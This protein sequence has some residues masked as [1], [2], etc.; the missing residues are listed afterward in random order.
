MEDTPIPKLK[1][2][3]PPRRF[4]AR[5]PRKRPND[6]RHRRFVSV[7]KLVLPLIAGTLIMLVAIWP[8]LGSEKSGF[9]IGFANL[10]VG[11]VTSQSLV[12]ARYE[13]TDRNERP[14]TVT[15]EL[16]TQDPGGAK[17]IRLI[18]PK[19]DILLDGGAW[20]VL[21]AESGSFERT[22]NT[23]ELNGGVT[24]LHDSGYEFR[25]ATATV[26]L[27]KGTAAGDREVVAQGPFGSFNATGFRVL[28]G[29]DQVIFTG[30][31][32]MV[33]YPQSAETR[34]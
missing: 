31:A 17:P 2:E 32:R 33:F 14:F 25:T 3:H 23:L 30:K 29:G 11:D 20:L 10:S 26:D 5:R 7:M 21:A 34:K 24:L 15:A 18:R 4:R 27:S 19:A 8:Q 16:A 22:A 1:P 28:G 6:T 13:G 12:N 9:R